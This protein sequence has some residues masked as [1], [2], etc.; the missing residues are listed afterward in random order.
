MRTRIRELIDEAAAALRRL[1][2]PRQAEIEAA[3]RLLIDC[4]MAG[5]SVYICGNG[6][7]AADAQHIAAELTGRYLRDRKALNCLALTVNTSN[8]TAIANDYGYDHVFAR[9]VEAHVRPGDVLWAISTSGKSPSILKAAGAARAR[10]ARVLGF[11]GANGQSLAAVSDVCFMAPAE[12]AY[13]IQ[14]LHELAYHILCD[15]VERHAEKI[16]AAGE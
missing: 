9:Q 13:A 6:G 3:A 15:L 10:G 11:T 8:L 4:F 5:R 14:Q 12:S 16:A 7:S 1:D 2:E